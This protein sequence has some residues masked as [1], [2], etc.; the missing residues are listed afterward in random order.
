[1]RLVFTQAFYNSQ[2]FD[3]SFL[4]I[5]DKVC[6][7]LQAE[8]LQRTI[9]K[10]GARRGCR[11]TIGLA[12]QLEIAIEEGAQSPSTPKQTSLSSKAAR[13]SLEESKA[14]RIKGPLKQK[15]VNVYN[16]TIIELYYYQVSIGLNKA[17]TF[18][19]ATYKALIKGLLYI[20]EE[21]SYNT[22]KDYRARGIDSS[23]N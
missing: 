4:V 12:L 6:A 10:R 18:Q 16:T 8:V 14:S 2:K 17:L 23:Y 15:T 22:F 9:P 19:G 1:M 11:Q 5:E 13:S 3:N 20:Q 21:R 7:Q